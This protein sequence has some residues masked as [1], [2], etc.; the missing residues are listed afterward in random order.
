MLSSLGK[1]SSSSLLLKSN[2]LS[3]FSSGG[4]D[5]IISSLESGELGSSL[6][7]SNSLEFNFSIEGSLLGV[8]FSLEL[9]SLGLSIGLL[10]S[11]LELV[12]LKEGLGLSN[13]ISMLGILGHL[14]GFD[15]V[16]L[17]LMLSFGSIELSFLSSI[18]SSHLGGVLGISSSLSFFFSLLSGSFSSSLCSF[19]LSFSISCGSIGGGLSISSNLNS[20]L[21]SGLLCSFSKSLS[22]QSIVLC[23]LSS[24]LSHINSD[25]FIWILIVTIAIALL[26]DSWKWISSE[27][28]IVTWS[29]SVVLGTFHSVWGLSELLEGSVG[30]LGGRSGTIENLTVAWASAVLTFMTAWLGLSWDWSFAPA[31]LCSSWGNIS[32]SCVFAIDSIVSWVLLSECPLNGLSEIHGSGWSFSLRS[33]VMHW[34]V[35]NATI[36]LALSALSSTLSNWS[37]LTVEESSLSESSGIEM[38]LGLDPSIITGSKLGL[39]IIILV[40]IALS[41][42]ISDSWG[43]ELLSAL[44][45]T[46][47]V[48]VLF[49]GGDWVFLRLQIDQVWV[50]VEI[51]GGFGVGETGIAGLDS[52]LLLSLFLPVELGFVKISKRVLLNNIWIS[53]EVA[54]SL[55]I[56]HV[57]SSNQRFLIKG[58]FNTLV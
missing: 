2:L 56:S 38:F 45:N 16:E 44:V 55:L 32:E 1:G 49:G 9:G 26:G 20:L 35:E 36:A 8:L 41:L 13:G 12:G 19:L 23:L 27:K 11:N 33:V 17:S 22:L 39:E 30:V 4:S 34:G 37:S 40:Q 48:E 10:G 25:L 5:L 51:A 57:S 7:G 28:V 15:H 42:L 54:L 53:I 47:V 29:H 14:S 6:L 50:S 43:A 31:L 46:P 3:S 24:E 52:L 18:L 58:G 21:F